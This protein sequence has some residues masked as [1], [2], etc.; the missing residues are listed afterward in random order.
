MQIEFYTSILP[1]PISMFVERKEKQNLAENL[2]EAIKV[3]KDLEAISNHPRNEENK[4][5]TYEK[6]GKKNKGTSKI[7]SGKKEKEPTD[8]DSM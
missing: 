8:M 1:T 2:E 6:N 5:F 3:K 7:D 4:S